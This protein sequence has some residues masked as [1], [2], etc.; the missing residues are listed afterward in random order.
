MDCRQG[1]NQMWTAYKLEE[2]DMEIVKYGLQRED[3]WTI[4]QRTDK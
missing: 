2:A 4:V 1:M 3:I